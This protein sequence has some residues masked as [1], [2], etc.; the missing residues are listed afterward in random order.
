MSASTI[1]RAG[2]PTGS[3]RNGRLA[4]FASA[5]SRSNGDDS[6]SAPSSSLTPG[7]AAGT[8]GW[9]GGIWGNTA[10]GSGFGNGNTEST[11][12]LV[13]ES[14][15]LKPG[16]PS[17][18]SKNASGS[19]VA[20][21]ETSA[22]GRQGL[23]WNSTGSTSPSHQNVRP[24]D[25]GSSPIRHRTNNQTSS[26]S[27]PDNSGSKSPYFSLPQ[28]A[29]GQG[30][31]SKSPHK[32][33]LDPT[34]GSFVTS[35][36][37]NDRS[38]NF[39]AFQR[40]S[41]DEENRRQLGSM[42]SPFE[43]NGNINERQGGPDAE[44]LASRP[45]AAL[46]SESLSH[47]RNGTDTGQYSMPPRDVSMF[48]RFPQD[49][50]TFNSHRPS[51]SGPTSSFP[52]RGNGRQSGLDDRKAE[53]VADMNRM[54]VGENGQQQSLYG[55]QFAAAAN[56]NAQLPGQTP[57]DF[58]Y[59]RQMQSNT[60]Q[61]VWNV[62][63]PAFQNGASTPEGFPETSFAD[64]LNAYRGP[65]FVDRNSG[66]PA[67]NDLRRNINSPFYS[68]G[69][70][71][72]TG[73]DQYR[74]PSR[75]SQSSRPTGH[76]ALLDRKLRGL[77][78]EQQNNFVPQGSQYLAQQ[79]RPSFNSY[80]Y[81]V[82]SG[83]RVNA[84]QPYFPV[85][86]FGSMGSGPVPPRGPARDQEYGQNLRSALLDEFRSNAKTSK[87][88]ELKDIYN[89]VV[90][91]SGDQHGSRFIQQKLETANSDEKDQ[92]FREIQPNSIQLMTDVFGNYVIQKFFEH[93][94]QSQKKILAN[95]MKGHVLTLS[96]QMYGCRVVQKA[97]EHILTDQQASLVK[98]LEAH[99]LKCVKDQNGN[100]VIQKAIERV[101]AEHIQFI[102]NAF[103]NQVQTLA[104][105]P[106]GCRVIQRMLEYCDES[107][108]LT[109]LQGLHACASSL[110][111]DQY[112]N[113]VTQHVIQHG[114]EDDR[115]K[116]VKLVIEQ[117]V[118]FSKHKFASN[119]VEKSIEYGSS[120]Q[121]HEIVAT[122]TTTN[123]NGESP[124][125]ALMRD[126]YG[127]YVIQKLLGQLK[128]AEYDEFV[129]S[130]QP[131]LAL[132]KKLTYG[133]QITAIEK[134]I[135]NSST[136][137]D[138]SRASTPHVHRTNISAAPTPPLTGGAQS[139]QSSSVP[140]ATSS[141]VEAPF[142]GTGK[143]ETGEEVEGGKVGEVG[144]ASA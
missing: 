108:Q 84:L 85:P 61:Q 11:R 22:W 112:G 144:I 64:Q 75:D 72:P 135:Y 79:L 56:A 121:R 138:R 43:N 14:P 113:Y 125:Q 4:D 37:T 123:E 46:G 116:I 109:I 73:S 100:H 141:T 129:E 130:I 90:E 105:H 27:F 55:Q 69:G 133:K 24:R 5:H 111:A 96:L 87:R 120:E 10:L 38:N 59:T 66:S 48:S 86:S 30:V 97:L 140:S 77:Q 71:P 89:H 76:P 50:N 134:L 107:S 20:S 33:A 128:G 54:A 117:L 118:V 119:V 131:Q 35:R 110:I 126:Q 1:N 44:Y 47:S 32:H 98:E 36:A 68:T 21:G 39:G 49:S 12:N 13:D 65:R 15:F 7:F 52:A 101:P 95:Q 78:Q 2:V 122:L 92:I 6:R 114:K 74:A 19:L 63:D 91:F 31:A 143:G 45:P 139:P 9:T 115:E 70:T 102:V 81:G 51:L 53:M 17:F 62:D 136:P 34:T 104:M 83:L 88:Y 8:S 40:F 137:P 3:I 132:L 29:I 103:H 58:G 142:T 26:Q 57:Y 124:L 94:N 127:N 18:D 16:N 25:A 99:V 41:A 67:A 106:Y 28:P 82:Q 23:P 93:G 42:M 80:E 60:P